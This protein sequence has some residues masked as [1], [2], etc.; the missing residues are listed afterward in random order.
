VQLVSSLDEVEQSLSVTRQQMSATAMASDG[1]SYDISE[2]R[3]QLEAHDIL[4]H[5]LAAIDTQLQ[6]ISSQAQ[7][8]DTN[9][10]GEFIGV[11]IF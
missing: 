3:Q 7:G 5:N 8:V 11:L 10:A 2:L 4:M 1:T 6:Q 9:I